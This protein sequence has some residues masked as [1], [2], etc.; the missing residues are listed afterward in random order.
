MNVSSRRPDRS[1][2]VRRLTAWLLLAGLSLN[3]G[4]L[5]ETVLPAQVA[6]SSLVVA[7]DQH[8]GR[9][10]ALPALPPALDVGLNADDTLDDALHLSSDLLAI[11]DTRYAHQVLAPAS[12][13]GR[14]RRLVSI[15]LHLFFAPLRC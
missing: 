8:Q 11:V 10:P 6:A 1:A 4:D 12:S 15:S 13:P 9:G 7:A 14:S 5:S 3:L 2:S